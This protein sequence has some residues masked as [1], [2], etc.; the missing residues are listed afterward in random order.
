MQLF[1]SERSPLN[2]NVNVNPMDSYISMSI[3]LEINTKLSSIS[4]NNE[5][6]KYL[7]INILIKYSSLNGKGSIINHNIP[8]SCNNDIDDMITNKWNTNII[9]D[10]K[11][12]TYSD[13][14]YYIY[15]VPHIAMDLYQNESSQTNCF[16]YL[17]SDDF[18]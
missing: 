5:W 18:C 4:F 14:H 8:F 1:K 13:I 3:K 11:L 2:V 6:M 10:C 16:V 9:I 7:S 17:Y 12:F 15:L